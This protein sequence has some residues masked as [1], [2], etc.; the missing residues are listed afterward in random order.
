MKKAP[1]PPAKSATPDLEPVVDPARPALWASLVF[2]IATMSLAYPG[3]TGQL[4]GNLHNDQYTLG[5]AFREFA[6]QSLRSGHGFPQWS[7]FLQED[8][9]TSPP[10]TATFS[11][12]PSS[13]G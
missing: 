11:T 5:Y 3:L 1:P 4:L 10:C 2:A 6:A 7:P 8:C 9:R 12:R 13:C